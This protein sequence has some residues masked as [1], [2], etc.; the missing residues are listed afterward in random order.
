MDRPQI[1]VF[2]RTGNKPKVMRNEGFIP[3]ALSRQDNDAL[4]LQAKATDLAIA[5]RAVGT[6]GVVELV[7]DTEAA[8][9]FLCIAREI[10][11]HPISH[12]LLNVSFQEVTQK[13][14]IHMT[15]PVVL[16]GTP[17]AVATGAGMLLQ[18]FEHI[19][20]T[21]QATS[22]PEHIEVD[23]SEMELDHALHISDIVLPEGAVSNTPPE[24]VIATLTLPKARTEETTEAEA[25][26][27]TPAAE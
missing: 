7:E 27:V 23:V 10:Q 15:I 21:I 4:S 25:P 6:S 26:A 1:P 13:Q 5:L 11:R 24:T 12:K 14:R 8:G 17:K 9:K 22:A 3:I 18:T 19:D 16:V 2:E 20:V